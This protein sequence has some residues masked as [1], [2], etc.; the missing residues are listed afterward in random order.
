MA[1]YLWVITD[2]KAGDEYPCIAVAQAL[3]IPFEIRRVNPRSIFAWAMPHGP[4]DPKDKP[5]AATSPIKPPYPD[6]AIA[7][8]RR[9]IA[10]LRKVKQLSGGKTFTVILKDPRNGV[11]AADLIWV[12]EHDKLRGD[13]VITTLTSPHRFSQTAQTE[14]RGKPLPEIVAL[15]K[16]RLAVLVGGNG[17]HANFTDRN[18]SDLMQA[19]K[20]QGETHSLMIT[21]SRRTPESLSKQL[22]C[23]A[24]SGKHLLWDGTGLNPLLQYLANADAVIVTTDS[25][26]M[27]GE[28]AS[29]GKPI[30]GF[31]P[32]G[33]HQKF[34]YFL[35][36]LTKMGVLHP[37]PGPMNGAPYT[38]IDATPQI[39]HAIQTAYEQAIA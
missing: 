33:G 19:L 38:P 5:T 37:F 25:S 27:V 12:C 39:V 2:G 28:A 11:G 17:R 13:N 22:Q 15:N 1:Q 35:N 34:D 24:N 8:G 32:D 36:E 10:Y 16:P 31:K 20:L 3:G 29:T 6:I 30:Y 7:S 4:I 21:T 9:S 18:I 14:A 26:N 23:L